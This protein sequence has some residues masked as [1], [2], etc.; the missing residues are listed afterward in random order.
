MKLPANRFVYGNWAVRL[1]EDIPFTISENTCSI[2]PGYKILGWCNAEDLSFRA[3]IEEF[4]VMF[5]SEDSGNEF[6]FHVD[7]EQFQKLIGNAH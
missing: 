7:K 1:G 2:F 4:A 5:F 6:W 3:K